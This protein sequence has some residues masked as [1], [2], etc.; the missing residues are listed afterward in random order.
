MRY[1]VV[2]TLGGLYK[3]GGFFFLRGGG[4]MEKNKNGKLTGWLGGELV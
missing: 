2:V 3:E 4:V 1:P